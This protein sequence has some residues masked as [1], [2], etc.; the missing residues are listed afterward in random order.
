MCGGAEQRQHG[1]EAALRVGGGKGVQ[2]SGTGHIKIDDEA[3]VVTIEGASVIG[4]G[5]GS[6]AGGAQACR[7]ERTDTHVH[8]QESH[9]QPSVLSHCSGR[10]YVY[11]K[12]L[13]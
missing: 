12:T 1:G 5:G 13:E 10:A 11:F 7:R 6:R 4:G 9:C 8:I 3:G 2:R